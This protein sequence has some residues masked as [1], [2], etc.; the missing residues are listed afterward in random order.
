MCSVAV[1]F[2]FL[3][4]LPVFPHFRIRA[5][6]IRVGNKLYFT[7]LEKEITLLIKDLMLLRGKVKV[8][9]GLKM[10]GRRLL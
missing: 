4:M 6:G 9:G 3:N 2:L 10:G 7:R 8:Q 5:R 1:L